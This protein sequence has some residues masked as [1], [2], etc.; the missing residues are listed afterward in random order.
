MLA[1]AFNP[2][3]GTLGITTGSPVLKS[4][5]ACLAKCQMLA[6]FWAFAIKFE[7]TITNKRYIPYFMISEKL[8]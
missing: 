4:S 6:W 1:F 2:K 3:K 5:P 7:K 8:G